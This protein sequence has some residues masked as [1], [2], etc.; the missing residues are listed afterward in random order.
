MFRRK[1]SRE[2]YYILFPYVRNKNRTL[3]LER[4]LRPYIKRKYRGKLK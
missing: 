4:K 3:V 2:V 1:F